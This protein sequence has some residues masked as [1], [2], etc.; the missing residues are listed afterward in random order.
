MTSQR[1]CGT[2][3]EFDVKSNGRTGLCRC[4]LNTKAD[5]YGGKHKYLNVSVDNKACP[6]YIMIKPQP[7]KE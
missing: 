6:A 3:Q 7:N 5:I 4:P 1:T 2:C